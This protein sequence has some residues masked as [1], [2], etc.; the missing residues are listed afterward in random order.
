M[1]RYKGII[2]DLDGTLIDSLGD[3]AEAGNRALKAF[4]L[5]TWPKEA[6]CDMIGHGADVLCQ[7]ASGLTGTKL[8]KF[9][10]KYRDTYAEIINQFSHPFPGIDVLLAQTRMLKRAIVTNKPQ[11]WAE[12]VVADLLPGEEF[13]TIIGQQVGRPLK[14]NPNTTLSV[15]ERW[16]LSGDEV[17][18]VGDM[19]VDVATARAARIPCIGVSW[20]FSSS[21]VMLA[22]K[23][24]Y[25]CAEPQEILRILKTSQK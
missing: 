6:Y 8:L 1:Y 9:T 21:D 10:Q 4:D 15:M 17:V 24:D 3:I 12:R 11:S 22:D 20:G 18:F 23:V 7:R 16:S 13:D 25:L 19:M 2:F 14:P 5:P